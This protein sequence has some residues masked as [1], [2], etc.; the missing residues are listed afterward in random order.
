MDNFPDANGGYTDWRAPTVGEINEAIANGLNIHLDFFRNG[1]PND[2]VYRLTG[3]LKKIKKQTYRYAVRYA[4]GDLQYYTTFGGV[5]GLSLVCVRGLPA[6]TQNDCPGG[7]GKKNRSSATRAVSQ[8]STGALL[9]LPL[10]V[11]M[12]TRCKK[13]RRP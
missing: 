6:D 12:A 4:D 9:L 2:F 10:A 11:V 1:T 13:E 8:I 5:S 7:H 3:C